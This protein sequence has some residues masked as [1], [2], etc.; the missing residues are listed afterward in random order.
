MAFN[1][2]ATIFAAEF[3]GLEDGTNKQGKP[4]VLMR[5]E[6]PAGRGFEVSTSDQSLFPAVHGMHK[7]SCYNLRCRMVSSQRYGMVQLL[8]YPQLVNAQGDE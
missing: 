2:D 4:Y 7:G 3:R 5:F 6:T 8:E 1:V